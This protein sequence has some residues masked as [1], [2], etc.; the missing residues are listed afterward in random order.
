MTAI[1]QESVRRRTAGR[2]VGALLVV[3]LGLGSTSAAWADDIDDR[4]AAAEQNAKK[5]QEERAELQEHLEETNAKFAKAVLDL[6]AVEARLPLAQAELDRAQADLEMA[7]R[8]AEILAQR[9][10]DAKD[11]EAA[12]TAEIAESAGKADQARSEIAQMARE[13]ARGQGDVSALGLVTGADSTEQFLRHYAVTTSASRSQSRTLTQLQDAEAVARNQEARLAAVRETITQLKKAADANVVVAKAAEEAAAERKA[14]VV[15]LVAEQKKLKASIEKQKATAL[16]EIEENEA[17]QAKIG[18]QIQGIIKEQK[19]RDARIAEERRKE[20]ERRKAAEEAARKA[21]AANKPAA[22]G[23][24]GSGGSG[25]GGGQAPAS[26]SFLHY[27]TKV[28]YVTSSY[29]M[30]FHPVLEIWR[31]HAGTDFRAYCGTPI[32]AAQSGFVEQAHFTSGGGNNILINHGSDG[33]ANIMTRYLHLS[34]M[35]VG[36][37]QWVSQGQQIGLS[38]NTGTSAACHL[39]FEVWVNGQTVDPMTRLP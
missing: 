10:Q 9:L 4:R 1:R 29:G 27:P 35:Q 30:R 31:L 16:A 25:G 38:G 26:T 33:G 19:E 2:A 32:F 34:S 36:V 7:R 39:H 12:V 8:E 17:Q 3:L 22:G 24:G 18:A 5:K 13:A 15:R 20:E 37:G 21:A 11:E 28:P 6:N 14:E 23:G